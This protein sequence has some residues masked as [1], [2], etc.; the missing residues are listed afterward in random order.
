MCNFWPRP[1]GRGPLGF[2]VVVIAL[3]EKKFGVLLLV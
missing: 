2:V 1:V 3:C